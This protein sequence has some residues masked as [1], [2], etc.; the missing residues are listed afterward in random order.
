MFRFKQF[1]INDDKCAMKVGT[2]GVLLG[3]WVDVEN[4]N[5]ILDVGTGSGLIALMLAQRTDAFIK[6]VEIEEKSYKQ[7]L[8]NVKKTRFKDR[9]EIFH[10][11]YQQF[12]SDDRFDLIISNPPFFEKSLKSPDC[13]RNFAR[14]NDT[15]SFEILIKKSVQLLSQKGRFAVIIPVDSF[16]SFNQTAEINGLNLIRKTNV[17]PT[18]VSSVK[19]TLLEYALLSENCMEDELLIE[20]S[21]H[22]YSNIYTELTKDFYLKM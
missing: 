6:G 14:H 22:V 2:D 3:A 9:I 19:R 21:R 12:L 17:R 20:I 4:C 10:S 11:S 18:P 16:M 8:E 5:S 7:A 13:H 15:L 1:T